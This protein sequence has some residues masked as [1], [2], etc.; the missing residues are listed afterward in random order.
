MIVCPFCKHEVFY[1][2]HDANCRFSGN[3]RPLWNEIYIEFAKLL[4]IRSTCARA[5]V[6]CVVAS[7]DSNRV[8]AIGYNGNY[9]NGPN[10]CDSE[11]PGNCGCLH[12]EDN[13]L[14]K[15]DFNDHS[16]KRMYTTVSPCKMCAKR[17]INAGIDEVVYD[18]LYRDSEGIDV[19]TGAGIPIIKY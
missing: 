2:N 13:A 10:V 15:L 7:W 4:S 1:R 18:I 17:I 9:R 19:L 6:G 16:K 11:E 5:S 3:G 12:A 8:L 14:L